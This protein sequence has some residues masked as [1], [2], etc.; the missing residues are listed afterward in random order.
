MSKTPSLPL[1][2]HMTLAAPKVV[3]PRRHQY[4]PLRQSKLIVA[5]RD[6]AGSPVLPRRRP[7]TTVNAKTAVRSHRASSIR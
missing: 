4:L 1:L 6:L 3:R 7:A 2:L 5:M